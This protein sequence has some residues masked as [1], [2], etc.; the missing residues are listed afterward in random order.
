MTEHE[1]TEMCYWYYNI[2]YPGTPVCRLEHKMT[3]DC[4]H[5]VK[6]IDYKPSVMPYWENDLSK[7]HKEK[8]DETILLARE[9]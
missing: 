7:K 2:G 8:I 4:R 3:D 6:C 9:P 5:F 1:V